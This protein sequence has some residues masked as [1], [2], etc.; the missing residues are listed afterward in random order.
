MSV[1]P[2]CGPP[3]VMDQGAT[4]SLDGRA[5]W[6]HMHAPLHIRPHQIKCP[7]SPAP[8]RL[9]S[10]CASL[11]THSYPGRQQQELFFKAYAGQDLSQ[12]QLDELCAEADVHSL[13]SH[14]YWGVWALIQACYSPVDFDYM[15]YSRMRWSECGRRWEEFMGRWRAV[16][17]EVEVQ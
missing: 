13:A 3:L 16:F 4:P 6:G 9:P 8:P 15:S 14:A 10:L 1:G 17:G 12:R 2:G 11:T 7:P 5:P